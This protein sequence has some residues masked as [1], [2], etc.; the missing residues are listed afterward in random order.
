MS[1]P[2][3]PSLGSTFKRISDGVSASRLIDECGLKGKRFGG[4]EI[5]QKH[6]GFIVNVDRGT[7]CDYIHL[8]EHT[9]ESVKEKFGIHLNMEVEI[10]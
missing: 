8:A 3:Q 2:S 9:K 1:Q 10:L 4:V 5:S 7:A 6:A